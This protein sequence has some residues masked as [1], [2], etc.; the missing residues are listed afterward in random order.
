MVKPVSRYHMI[1]GLRNVSI[2]SESEMEIP[3]ISSTPSIPTRLPPV[4]QPPQKITTYRVNDNTVNEYVWLYNRY[5]QLESSRVDTI[6]LI[7]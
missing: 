7:A 6:N 5:G 1:S 4:E 2:W 3:E